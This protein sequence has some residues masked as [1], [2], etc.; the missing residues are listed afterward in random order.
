MYDLAI[1]CYQKGDYPKANRTVS[2]LINSLNFVDEG[3]KEISFG[4]LRLYQFAQDQS[5]KGNLEVSIKILQDL[6]ETWSIVFQR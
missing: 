4:L 5:R 1:L 2:E 3:A 6:R